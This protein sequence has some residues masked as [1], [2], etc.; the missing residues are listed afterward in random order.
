MTRL[1][2]SCGK[3]G[4]VVIS[5]SHLRHEMNVCGCGHSYV[6]LEEHYSRE[7]GDVISISRKENIDGQWKEIEGVR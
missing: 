3:C 5:Y 2:W 4:D 1:I 7:G 6:D